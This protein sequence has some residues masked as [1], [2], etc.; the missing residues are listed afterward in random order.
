MCFFGEALGALGAL[1]VLDFS[2]FERDAMNAARQLTPCSAGRTHGHIG[3]GGWRSNCVRRVGFGAALYLGHLSLDLDAHMNGESALQ[4][5]GEQSSVQ[6]RC[7]ILSIERAVLQPATAK[8]DRPIGV[9]FTVTQSHAIFF[10]LR[11]CCIRE[12]GLHEAPI[13]SL[14]AA[15][16]LSGKSSKFFARWSPP[17]P[18]RYSVR[19]LNW[20]NRMA[21]IYGYSIYRICI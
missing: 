10:S 9:S 18:I 16:S 13:F 17:D 6:P 3:G 1:G 7:L 2:T 15:C 20:L 12:E 4:L 19:Q 5:M 11:R 14:T 8:R 21:C